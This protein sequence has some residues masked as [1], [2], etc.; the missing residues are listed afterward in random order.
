MANK[1]IKPFSIFLLQ[2]QF[3]YVIITKSAKIKALQI[4][5][6]NIIQVR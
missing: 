1:N 4:S 6:F 2:I 5:T 3:N